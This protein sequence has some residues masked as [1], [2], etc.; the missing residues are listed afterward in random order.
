MF[1]LY[2]QFPN[3]SPIQVSSQASNVIRFGY[4]NVID[5]HLR[6]ILILQSEIY[7]HTFRPIYFDPINLKPV[8]YIT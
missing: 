8:F 3:E 4:S 6:A 5:F 7:L 1:R 2:V